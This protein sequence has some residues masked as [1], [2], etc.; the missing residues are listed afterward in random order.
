MKK[1]IVLL[2]VFILTIPVDA[3]PKWGKRLPF[4]PKG[5]Y[6]KLR[7]KQCK[8]VREKRSYIFTQWGRN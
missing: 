6:G 2:L 4:A 8:P 3:T 7:T 5:K 1:L